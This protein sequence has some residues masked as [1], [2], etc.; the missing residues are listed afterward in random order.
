MTMR[1]VIADDSTLMREGLSRLLADS[2]IDVVATS[3][4]GEGLLRDVAREGPD[5]AV[6]DIRMPPSFTDEGIVAA[7]SIR[8]DHPDVGILIL[9]HHLES[10]YALSVMNE[11]PSG[12]GYLL[13]ERVSA[14]EVLVDALHRVDEGEC[15]IDP[16]IVARLLQSTRRRGPLDALTARELEVLTL[17]AEGCSN[18]AIGARLFLSPRTVEHHVRGVFDKLGLDES[19]ESHRRVLAVI[20]YL[21][22][23]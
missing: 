12:V 23:P 14:V 6:I 8:A 17:M 21:R 2:G 18:Q 7:R 9:S 20:A 19:S 10:E 5:V 11:V 22:G 15:V 4:D 3:A 16:T 1:V 13:K